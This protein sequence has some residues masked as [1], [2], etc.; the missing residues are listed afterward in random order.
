MR[1][2]LASG[3]PRRAELLSALGT[4]F[5]IVVPDVDETPR[6]DEGPA[7]L[8]A[9]LSRAKADA[10]DTAPDVTVVA[11]D[12]VVVVDGTMLGKPDD[13]ADAARML[14]RLSGRT[15]EVITGIAVRRGDRCVHEVCATAVTLRPLSDPEIDDYVASGDPLD[16]AGAYGIQSGAARFVDRVDG[17][18]QSVVG[19]PLT[20]LERCLA[21]LD[22]GDDLDDPAAGDAAG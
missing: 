13:A 21:A 6:A 22:A 10:V 17:N 4:P 12:T 18:Y 20:A 15:H 19:L 2:I 9:R 8:V 5:E 16:K 7:A 1:L 14:R 3:S 11:A